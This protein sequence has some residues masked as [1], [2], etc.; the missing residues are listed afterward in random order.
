MNGIIS[1]KA[2][3]CKRYFLVFAAMLLV[4]LSSCSIKSGIKSLAGIP[5]GTERTLPKSNQYFSSSPVETCAEFDIADTQIVQ[6]FSFNA[7]DLQ[8]VASLKISKENRHPVYSGSSKIRS[9]I[10]IFLEYQKLILH[11]SH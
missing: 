6:K 7:N 5:V 8:P 2:N 11:F 10:P 1:N 3:N 9:T 4:L